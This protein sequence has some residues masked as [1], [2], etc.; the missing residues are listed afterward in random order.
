M[1]SMKKGKGKRIV[2]GGY[3]PVDLNNKLILYCIARQTRKSNAIGD[4]LDW[5]FK[6]G[7]IKT[8]DLIS[9]IIKY[10]QLKWEQKK[11]VLRGGDIAKEKEL[12]IRKLRQE[13]LDKGLPQELVNR[14]VQ[15][16]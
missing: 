8:E 4:A 10:N 1:I 7:K 2:V 9:D 16:V 14:I 12:F 6:R 5:F 3:I 11:I 13:Y 15:E